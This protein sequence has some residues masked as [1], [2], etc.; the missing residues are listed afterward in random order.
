MI[1]VAAGALLALPA[2][3]QQPLSL[4]DAIRRGLETNERYRITL[5]EQDRADARIKQARA[6][7]LPDIRSTGRTRAISRFR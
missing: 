6:G 7:I 5:A 1:A 4:T 3:A 2:Y